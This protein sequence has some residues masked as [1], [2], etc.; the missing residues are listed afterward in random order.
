MTFRAHET[1]RYAVRWSDEDGDHR[2][3]YARLTSAT[4]FFLTLAC[5]NKGRDL[6]LVDTTSGE[7]LETHN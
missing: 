2:T 7:V 4:S 1:K 3:H 5:L 6:M